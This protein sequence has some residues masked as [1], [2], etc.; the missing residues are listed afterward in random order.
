MGTQHRLIKVGRVGN[1]PLSGGVWGG[2]LSMSSGLW[3]P[4]TSLDKHVW[5][6]VLCSDRA[7]ST[8]FWI[9]SQFGVGSPSKE[10]SCKLLGLI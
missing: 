4:N 8:I 1:E 5:D 3:S 9:S 7:S 10:L 2:C 6:S